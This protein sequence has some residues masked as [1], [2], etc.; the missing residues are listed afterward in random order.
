M[1]LTTA[2]LFVLLASVKT[3][4]TEIDKKTTLSQR[5]NNGKCNFIP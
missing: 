4:K 3:N 2:F 1:R 5:K